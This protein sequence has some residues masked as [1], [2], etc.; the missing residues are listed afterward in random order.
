MLLSKV[1]HI[2]KSCL[3]LKSGFFLSVYWFVNLTLSDKH[4]TKNLQGLIPPWFPKT[5]SKKKLT[6]CYLNRASKSHEV[7]E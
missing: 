7:S 2:Q 6:S 4:G 3:S 1:D 5:M